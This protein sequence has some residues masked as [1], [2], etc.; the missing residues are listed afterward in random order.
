MTMTDPGRLGRKIVR[1]SKGA[2]RQV[3]RHSRDL[4]KL[5]RATYEYLPDRGVI[6]YQKVGWPLTSFDTTRNNVVHTMD[7]MPDKVSFAGTDMMQS[8]HLEFAKAYIAEGDRFQYRNTRYY[9]L[10]LEGRLPF[11]CRGQRDAEN[12]CRNFIYLINKLKEDGYTPVENGAITLVPCVDG[13]HMIINGKHR[14][15]AL[16]A[17]GQ[18]TFDVF[19]GLA[20]EVRSQFRQ[21][22]EAAWPRSSYARSIDLLDR[23]GRPHADKGEQI[24]ALIEH[25]HNANLENWGDIYH[26]LPFYEFRN[27]QTQVDHDT[28][29]QRLQMIL[30]HSG[31]LEG[32]NVLDLGCNLG[33]YSFSL[34]MRGAN[35]HSVEVREDYGY[36]SKQLVDIY[37]VP[38]NFINEPL[39]PELLEKVGDVDVTLCFSMIQWV[40]DQM[41]MEYGL[42]LLDRISKQ[43]RSLFFDV[44]VNEGKACLTCP[45]GEELIFVERL[46]NDSTTYPNI[47]YIGKVHPYKMDTRYI[48]HCSH[49]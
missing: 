31:N 15:A 41:G 11:P 32:K 36:I 22:A 7:F 8:P 14:F 27:M 37:E 20:N 23:I 47:N 4:V 34:A 33:F 1:R 26:P 24:N 10:A 19:I 9:R 38:V 16:I 40:I 13:S 29:Y 21:V 25:I 2:A 6:S 49:D 18:T 45:E 43:S 44:S 42:D 30:A 28:P 12:L 3:L 5:A 17:L 46:L 35:L 48:F 39:S